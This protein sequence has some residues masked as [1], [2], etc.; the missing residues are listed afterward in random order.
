MSGNSDTLEGVG[1]DIVGCEAGSG[2]EIFMLN[3]GQENT[4]KLTYFSLYQS[5][6]SRRSMFIVHCARRQ[7]TTQLHHM[8]VVTG[9]FI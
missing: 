3:R 2:D 7:T 9:L 1:S 5:T 4:D 8:M 6:K